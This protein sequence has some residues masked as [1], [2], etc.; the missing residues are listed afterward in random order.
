MN[1]RNLARCLPAMIAL[2][3]ALTIPGG[4]Q[5][6][7][8]PRGSGLRRAWS[9]DRI[10][11]S[12]SAGDVREISTSGG[13]ECTTPTS[14][15]QNKL[16]ECP[17]D[18]SFLT[19]EPAIVVDPSDPDHM[20]AGSFEFR[21][22]NPWG[23]YHQ[24]EFYVTVDGGK[25]WTSGDL[26]LST[27]NDSTGD[28][29]LS[30][31][32]KHGHFIYSFVNWRWS[33][34]LTPCD[35]D[36]RVATSVAGL[37]WTVGTAADGQGCVDGPNTAF[38]KPWIVTDNNPTS[39]HY[40]RTYLVA[41]YS[42]CTGP[43]GCTPLVD[44]IDTIGESH[45]DDG[46]LTW[47]PSKQISGSNPTYC[48]GPPN[49]PACDVSFWAFP[50]I[51]PDGSLHVGFENE[52]H[53][54]AWEAG[55]CCE[56]QYMVVSSTD[57]GD[58]WSAPVHVIDQEDGSRDLAYCSVAQ[59]LACLTDSQISGTIGGAPY[60]YGILASS[61]INGTLYLTF[62]DNRNGLHDVDDPVTNLDVFVMASE[63]GGTTWSG[64]DVVSDAPSDQF[65]PFDAVDPVTG[66]LGVE[67]YDRSYGTDHRVDLTLATGQP[68][69]FSL[70]RITTA[71][72]HLD[73]SLWTPASLF[74]ASDCRTCTIFAADYIGMAYGPDGAANL[75]WDDMRRPAAAPGGRTGYTEN[76][77]YSSFGG[78]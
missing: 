55:E 44:E 20:V 73:D 57:G 8:A 19:I 67:F 66:A 23:L 32:A 37:D 38:D 24:M 61:P 42:Q 43:S 14:Q 12:P 28:P 15:D 63:D 39:P 70:A 16:L 65:M 74:G 10:A 33:A 47:S 71:S 72:S 22:K 46:G 11:L 9:W 41:T 30:F 76:I 5:A 64:P 31:D 21:P 68:G 78:S 6:G 51:S 13:V 53:T 35:I 4:A 75:V 18:A 58:T 3:V 59:T 49:P 36:V 1:A 26:P 45:S 77:F 60:G 27:P 50:T 56:D 25:T 40:G 69:A 54:A 34:D 62:A 52:Q 17:A 29:S 48:T 2:L 7:T